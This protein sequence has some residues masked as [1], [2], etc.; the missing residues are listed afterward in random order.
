MLRINVNYPRIMSIL[1]TTGLLACAGIFSSAVLS[2]QQFEAS[3]GEFSESDLLKTYGF[4]IASQVGLA[5]MDLEKEQVDALVEGMH[6]ALENNEPPFPFEEIGP[7]LQAFLQ[8]KQEVAGAR[9]AEAGRAAAEVFF[10][11]LAERDDVERTDSGLYYEVIEL[12]DGDR[13]GPDDTVRIHYSG[14]LISGEVFDSSHA[15]GEPAEFPV[16][17]VIPGM[18]EGL[19]LLPVGSEAILYIPADLGYGNQ[20][21]GN[22]PPGSTLIFEVE[23]IDIVD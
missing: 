8:Q 20:G 12:G 2:G 7:Q 23:V 14:S 15:R 9:A 18:S 10:S 6:Y 17:G 4:L 11:E 19:Q 3:G 13:P 1:K 21:T 22:I 16:M 5:E